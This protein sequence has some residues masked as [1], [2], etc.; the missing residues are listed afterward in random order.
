MRITMFLALVVLFASCEKKSGNNFPKKMDNH[1]RMVL[2]SAWK[3]GDR[4][5]A[6][7]AIQSLLTRDT[8]N[9]GLMDTLTKLYMQVNNFNSAFIVSKKLIERDS[10]TVQQ[11]EDY[12][13]CA[14][15]LG[16]SQEAFDA[17]IGLYEKENNS[18]YLYEIAIQKM[19]MGK[20]DEAQQFLASLFND[21]RAKT[22]QYD[23]ELPDGRI[24]R[25]PVVSAAHFLMGTY[26]QDVLKNND[27]AE[28][29]YKTT[30]EYAPGFYPANQRLSLINK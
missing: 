5:T 20:M 24:M 10:S 15:K 26:N 16:A 22:D 6:I 8:A 2:E 9:Y 21:E 11:W 13:K 7:Y 14:K 17:F 3:T 27:Q 25:M 30:L 28:I 29:H 23:Y 4:Q 1:D 12:A 18:K 19:N